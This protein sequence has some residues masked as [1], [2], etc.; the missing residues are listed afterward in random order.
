MFVTTSPGKQKS[1]S[2]SRLLC[3]GLFDATAL[4]TLRGCVTLLNGE[5][6]VPGGLCTP[7]AVVVMPERVDVLR[8]TLLARFAVN[9]QCAP[10]A[11]L[12]SS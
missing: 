6:G 7:H 12:R 4:M 8:T 3:T 1:P 10:V 2:D 11:R 9:G 5:L